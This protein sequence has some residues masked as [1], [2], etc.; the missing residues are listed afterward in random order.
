MTAPTHAWVLDLVLRDGTVML[1]VTEPVSGMVELEPISGWSLADATTALRNVIARTAPRT[2]Q[3]I[4]TDRG[5]FFAGLG[6]AMGIEQQFT[7]FT[8]QRRLER[9]QGPSK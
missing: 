6:E 2:P 3:T 7:T 1:A 4:I 5:R 8:D 9:L